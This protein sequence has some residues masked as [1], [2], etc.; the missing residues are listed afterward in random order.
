M[1]VRISSYPVGFIYI[2]EKLDV[3]FSLLCS[4]M[5]CANNR[6][7]C[8]LKVVFFCLQITLPHYHH[9]ADVSECIELLDI[10]SLSSVCLSQFSRLSFMQYM[11]LC[12]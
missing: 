8:G 3:I 9:Y 1:V 6:V 10:Y 4:L 11:G 7:H 2:L 12:V 5:T